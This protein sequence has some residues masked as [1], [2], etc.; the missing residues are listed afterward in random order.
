MMIVLR[1]VAVWTGMNGVGLAALVLSHLDVISDD[2]GHSKPFSASVVTAVILVILTAVSA[3]ALWG[4]VQLWRLR[5]VGRQVSAA[6]LL[7]SS[8]FLAGS[9]IVT[10]DP[11]IP[12]IPLV[13]ALTA[14]TLLL[15][16]AARV[17]CRRASEAEAPHGSHGVA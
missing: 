12:L 16:P 13:V 8:L 10:R 9:V 7:A 1:I 14:S 15:V 5:N 11:A 6:Y 17:A 4:A 2:L 3:V